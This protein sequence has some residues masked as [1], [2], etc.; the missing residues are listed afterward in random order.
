MSFEAI[1]MIIG[2]KDK[3]EVFMDLEKVMNK[4]NESY[5]SNVNVKIVFGDPIEKDGITIIPVAKVQAK[6]GEG[7]TF[8][9]RIGSPEYKERNQK[10]EEEKDGSSET[11]EK[12]IEKAGYGI[13]AKLTPLGYIEIKNGKADFK[14][15]LDLSRIAMMGICFAGFSVFL[16]TRMMSR[17]AHSLLKN[18]RKDSCNCHEKEGCCSSEKESCC[19]EKK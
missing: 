2:Q 8:Q 5:T 6:V 15:I 3:K 7:N 1:Q 12:K 18:Q 19:C 11:E 13:D 16:M 17:I 9:I 10:E 4:I 14:P